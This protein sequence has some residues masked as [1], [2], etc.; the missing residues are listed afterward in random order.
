MRLKKRIVSV[1]LAG[2]L[3]FTTIFSS[4]VTNAQVKYDPLDERN[5]GIYID[6]VAVPD[7]E[8]ISVSGA[9]G[10]QTI[11]SVTNVTF[12]LYS[13]VDS[14]WS[15]VA[16]DSKNESV[17]NGDVA[18]DSDSGQVS[19]SKHA[20]V[21]FYKIT[22]E[23]QNVK[24]IKNAQIVLKVK[25]KPAKATNIRWDESA[26]ND[27]QMT[28]SENGKTL[29]IDGKV[30]EKNLKV[31]Y[32]PE[33]LLDNTVSFKG[34][35]SVYALNG[36]KKNLFTSLDCTEEN[37]SA[38][39]VSYVGEMTDEDNVQATAN[40]G[41]A[42]S[43]KALAVAVDSP[44]F[45]EKNL[46]N[47]YT[48]QRDQYIHFNLNSNES[49]TLDSG[50]NVTINEVTWSLKQND[51]E[52]EEEEETKTIDHVKYKVY[53]VYGY[54]GTKSYPVGE[55]L[56]SAETK[57]DKI[58]IRTEKETDAKSVDALKLSGT[59]TTNSD[60]AGNSFSTPTITVKFNTDQV[61]T[62]NNAYLDF[63]SKLKRDEDFSV[64]EKSLIV[65]GVAQDVYY[66]ESNE[67]NLDLPDVTVA[68][69][70]GVRSFEESKSNSFQNGQR[71]S[72]IYQLDDVDSRVFGSDEAAK[73]YN[74]LNL[75][76]SEFN[77]AK[78]LVNNATFTKTGTGYK[79]LTVQ[80]KKGI[81]IISEKVYYIRFVSPSDD[82]D[83]VS[84]QNENELRIS[85]GENFWY[86]LDK[87][88][89]VH[90]RRG[91]GIIPG[92]YQRVVDS[93]NWEAQYNI[94]IF[95]PYIEY[96]ISDE[97]IANANLNSEKTYRVN[98]INTGIV[99][100]TAHG[101]V[102]KS[103]SKTFTL[104]V[105][106]DIYQ[107]GFEIDFTDAIESKLMSSNNVIEGRQNSVP[108]GLRALDANL[109]FPIVTWSLK[110]ANDYT[111]PISEVATINEKTGV[112]TTKKSSEG[113]AII[114]TATDGVNSNSKSFT[115]A[116]ID[117]T[118]IKTLAEKVEVGNTGV[119]TS[120]GENAGEVKAGKSFTL[121]P[122]DYLPVQA[123]KLNGTITWKSDNTEYATVDS[124][125]VVTALKETP[126]DKPITITATYTQSG[127]APVPTVYKLT[128]KPG[129]LVT[130][131]T[132][133]DVVLEYPGD[134]KNIAATVL[135]ED[136]LDKNLTYT[137]SDDSVAKVNES[138]QITAI[139]AGTCT[140]TI[141]STAVPTVSKVINVTVKGEIVIP[142]TPEPQITPKPTA[143]PEPAA[144]ATPKPTATATPEPTAVPKPEVPSLT[145]IVASAKAGTIRIGGTTTI[146]VLKVPNTATEKISF[147][148]SA[149]NIVSVSA[150]GVVKGIKPG[151][152]VI[153]VT[154]GNCSSMVTIKVAKNPTAKL[155]KTT[156]KKKKS[157]KVKISNKVS[158]AKVTYSSSKKKVAKVSKSGKVTGV[159]KG[160]AK[161]TVK[162]TQLGKTYK[163]VLKVKVK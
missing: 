156:I 103:D 95:N 78:G 93:G 64:K 62:I 115:I 123:T 42:I 149:S 63:A 157:T 39:I 50:K 124:N 109:G 6:T 132:A 88:E 67:E 49:Q 16:E 104:Y 74:N 57:S 2:V 37:E 72:V 138:G 153:V 116:E 89:T 82:L 143:T 31:K 7:D 24:T 121:Y 128:I 162:I 130:N 111:T 87:G 1:A 71:Y 14:T 34:S 136:A 158:G 98:G 56:V 84:G 70:A 19:I 10:A 33:Y 137:S 160:S 126:A 25:D 101:A 32:E 127:K 86:A 161:I 147:V 150:T 144:T 65:D 134:T 129:I 30:D 154:A 59:V 47:I 91:E 8:N 36:D 73:K 61:A 38:E 11:T 20:R 9:Q 45:K 102:N 60:N 80:C 148:S 141:S 77:D 46:N 99:T 75:V 145:S 79:K 21:G 97:N 85:K 113:N 23:P 54:V 83:N 52:L 155:A 131:I 12:K 35:S 17:R 41:V 55:V 120:L 48:L 90:V 92:F 76:E 15:I 3:V 40:L 122:V 4:N 108:V 133:E 139:A 100:V 81:T 106:K 159:K 68:D 117:A 66:F 96:D 125:G 110:W 44:E 112:I 28:V 43:E 140:V 26:M 118:S 51:I 53:K 135:P 105:N 151:T 13:S 152:A 5:N 114:V 69:V 119:V 27:A 107:G 29:N 58:I 163:K 94:S 18:I 146:N 22:A 142:N